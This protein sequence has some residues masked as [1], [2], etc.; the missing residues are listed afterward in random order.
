[1]LILKAISNTIANDFPEEHIARLKMHNVQSFWMHMGLACILL[2]SLLSAKTGNAQAL[3]FWLGALTVTGFI[4]LSHNS[5]EIKPSNIDPFSTKKWVSKYILLT[6]LMSSLWGAAGIFMVSFVPV[7]QTTLLIL[8]I[9]VLIATIPLLLASKAAFFA[10]FISIL[11][12]LTFSLSFNFSSKDHMLL[13]VCIIA[14]AITIIFASSYLNQIITQLQETQRALQAQADTDQLTQLANRRAFDASFKKEW[15][16]ST[17]EQKEMALLIIDVDD[18]KVYNDTLGHFAGDECLKKIA[19]EIQVNARRP[20]DVAAR[21]GGE[22]FAILLPETG[23]GGAYNVAERLQK[24]VDRLDI[25]HPLDRTRKVTISIGVSSCT[26][27]QTDIDEQ[28]RDV[29]YP[30]MLMKSA[31]SAMYRAKREGKNTIVIEDCGMPSS[32]LSSKKPLGN[33]QTEMLAL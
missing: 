15:R 13:S 19:R 30:A 32:S 6:T 27:V 26:P 1:M 20:S 18:F 24:S 28:Q 14:L 2:I 7:I 25:V 21:I 23:T 22:E 31:D 33:G 3:V 16:R 4:R 12:P 5:S 8:L 17:R 11:A 9:S 29:V 10:Q